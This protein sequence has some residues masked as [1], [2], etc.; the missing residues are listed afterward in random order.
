M[1]DVQ[2]FILKRA[3]QKVAYDST[4]D[5]EPDTTLDIEPDTTLDTVSEPIT[6]TEENPDKQTESA[7]NSVLD[8]KPKDLFDLTDKKEA[9]AYIRLVEAIKNKATRSAIYSGVGGLAAG[10]GLGVLGGLGVN[11]LLGNTSTKS[12]II[13]SLLGGLA[14]GL[15]AGIGAAK[16]NYDKTLNKYLD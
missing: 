15:P 6:K 2:K 3:M 4:L 11:K 9:E 16:Y 14:V 12:K 10:G 7:T 8:I 5:V 13:A 1:N